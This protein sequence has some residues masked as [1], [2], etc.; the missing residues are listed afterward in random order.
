M[1][2]YILTSLSLLFINF[3]IAQIDTTNRGCSTPDIDTTE[4]QQLPWFDNNQ[5]LEN[6]LDSIGY[7][8]AGSGNRI[9]GDPV[10][11]WIPI[12]FWIYRDD[13]GNGGPTQFQ[14]QRMIDKL[15]IINVLIFCG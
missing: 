13:N 15:N 6:F 4:F 12:K 2:K 9:V 1:K 10:R 11:F 3:A 5:F 7:P 8:A 14:I